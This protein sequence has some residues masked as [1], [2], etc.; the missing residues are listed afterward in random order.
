LACMYL[1]N[2]HRRLMYFFSC[3]DVIVPFTL[4][5]VSVGQGSLISGLDCTIPPLR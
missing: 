2:D 1:P 5:L 3:L 4:L